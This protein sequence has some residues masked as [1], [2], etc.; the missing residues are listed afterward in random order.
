MN[1]IVS[2]VEEEAAF[3]FLSAHESDY[4]KVKRTLLDRGYRH[5]AADLHVSG[6]SYFT[7]TKRFTAS[8]R[9]VSVLLTVHENVPDLVAITVF[10]YA[11]N[12]REKLKGS[13]AEIDSLLTQAEVHALNHD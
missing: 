10:A 13:A 12:G 1:K 4:Q 3:D 7:W 5:E 11:P 8:V 2:L 6:L 9:M